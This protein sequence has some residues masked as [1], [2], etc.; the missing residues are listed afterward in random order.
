MIGACVTY[1]GRW[2]SQGV[3]MHG[4]GRAKSCGQYKTCLPS[5]E[6]RIKT[7]PADSGVHWF[8]L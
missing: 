5:S 3:W 8:T 1:R 7:N 6:V 4:E 2:N